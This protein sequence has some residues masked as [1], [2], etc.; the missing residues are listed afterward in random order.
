MFTLSRTGLTTVLRT[1][2]TGTAL[3]LALAGCTASGSGAS[4]LAASAPAASAPV[5]SAPAAS[6]PA[7]SAQTKVAACKSLETSVSSSTAE[8]ASSFGEIATNP[9]R[10]ISGLQS[11]ADAFDAGLKKV[12][13]A[14]V[15]RAGTAADDSIKEMIMQVK[16]VVGTPSADTTKLKAAVTDVQAEFTAIGKLCS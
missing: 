1:A 6:A 15:K 11:V 13:N 7:A 8:L 16:A 14:E 3:A 5:A 9:D 2:V 4:S 10:A 12:S